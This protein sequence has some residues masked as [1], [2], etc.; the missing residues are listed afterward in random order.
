MEKISPFNCV[1]QGSHPEKEG[2]YLYKL[3]TI[4]IPYRCIG[5][6]DG[7]LEFIFKY[8]RKGLSN[9]KPVPES[10][11]VGLKI[12]M[13]SDLIGCD[14]LTLF[15]DL[16]RITPLQ[17]SY[18]LDSVDAVFTRDGKV[19]IPKDAKPGLEGVIEKTLSR[20][21]TIFSVDRYVSA[22]GDAITKS[23][24]EK[25]LPRIHTA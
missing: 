21:T 19:F 23:I 13:V 24:I 17:N 25:N 15:D 3:S 8:E 4:D 14:G 20:I 18:K 7:R 22:Y 6:S 2:S 12:A 5:I 16:A 9:L 1:I 10:E 11:L